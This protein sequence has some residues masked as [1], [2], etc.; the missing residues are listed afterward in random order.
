MKFE[1]T[2]DTVFASTGSAPFDPEKPGVLFVHGAGMDHSVWV[3]PARYFARHGYAVLA[4]DFPAHGRSAGAALTSVTAMAR[5][6][7][8][9]LDTL[10]VARTAVVGHSMGS[11]VAHSFA[12]LY[13]DRCRALALLGTSAPMPVTPLLLNAAE[14]NDH[15]AIDMANGWSHSARGKLGGNQNPGLWMLR[16]GERLLERSAPGVF[17]ADLIACNEFAVREGEDVRCPS[18]VI[19]GEADQMTPARAG[20]SVAEQLPEA[21]IVRLPGCGHSM[22]SERPNDVLDA[23]IQIV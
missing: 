3:M 10:G 5:W 2:G 20:I 19:V 22:I 12:R 11:L 7:A 21:T 16:G 4:P 1:V 8:V 6:L 23:L 17:H 15:A 9:V 14:D 13:P 18:L